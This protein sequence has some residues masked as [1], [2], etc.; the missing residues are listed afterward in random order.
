MF[1]F[2]LVTLCVM[3]VTQSSFTVQLSKWGVAI[4]ITIADVAYSRF[5]L[6]DKVLY[7]VSDKILLAIKPSD[8]S[9]AGR[10][11]LYLALKQH[12]LFIEEQYKSKTVIDVLDVSYAYSDYQDEGMYC[13]IISWLNDCHEAELN[14]PAVKFDSVKNRYVFSV[15]VG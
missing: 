8:F 13:V 14:M 2:I 7:A 15:V 12:I 1:P 4:T 9:E 11:Y 10:N 5:K 6:G 3:S